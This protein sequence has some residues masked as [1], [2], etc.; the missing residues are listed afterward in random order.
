MKI[1]VV[2]FVFANFNLDFR[3]KTQNPKPETINKE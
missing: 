2:F 1:I 3:F